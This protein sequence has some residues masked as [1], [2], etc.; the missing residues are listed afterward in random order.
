MKEQKNMISLFS[1]R[2]YR[3]AT[4]GSRCSGGIEG[5]GLGVRPSA[6]LLST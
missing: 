5:T 1:K 2:Y 6:S 3:E 4:I